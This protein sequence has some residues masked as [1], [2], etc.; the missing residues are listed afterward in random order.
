[1]ECIFCKIINKEVPSEVVY[2]DDDVLVFKDVNPKA[3]IHFLMIPKEHIAS[4][5]S[6]NSENIVG[7][8]VSV[9]KKIAEEKD[10]LGY[11][12]VFN[13]GREQIVEHLHMHLL[14]AEG[15]GELPSQLNV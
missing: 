12:L 9:A 3:P 10:I 8:L 7:N 15:A 1:M 13:V 2:E 5:A 4:I 14:A 6:S 11:K